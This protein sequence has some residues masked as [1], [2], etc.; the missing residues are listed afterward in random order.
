[1]Y[2]SQEKRLQRGFRELYSDGI[3]SIRVA[4]GSGLE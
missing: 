1:M 4:N 3:E 2:G